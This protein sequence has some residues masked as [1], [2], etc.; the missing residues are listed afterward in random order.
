MTSVAVT[1]EPAAVPAR[2]KGFRATLA[3]IFGRKAKV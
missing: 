3:K 1:T 2:R